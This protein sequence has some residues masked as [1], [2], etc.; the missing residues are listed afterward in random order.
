MTDTDSLNILTDG[1]CLPPY[2]CKCCVVFKQFD[3]L[4]F[5]GLA[6]KPQKRQNF[7]IYGNVAK[8]RLVHNLYRINFSV[9]SDLE[10]TC[11]LCWES[12]FYPDS[13]IAME[14]KTI[15]AYVA[16]DHFL[17]QPK[18]VKSITCTVHTKRRS[19]S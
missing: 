2:T 6:G 13:F 15:P 18:T 16:T 19:D 9:D 10:H 8:L 12:Y 11:S 14:L 1:H 7:A 4:N 17:P 5:D 3:G